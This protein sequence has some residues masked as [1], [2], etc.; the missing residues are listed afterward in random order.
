M[1]RA[2][3]LY[4]Q[5]G[6][7]KGNEKEKERARTPPS[8]ARYRVYERPLFAEQKSGL[9][10]TSERVK[11][12]TGLNQEQVGHIERLCFSELVKVTDPSHHPCALSPRNL[13]LLTL[14]WLWRYP[15]L[16]L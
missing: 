13:L 5:S 7:S 16:R 11:L 14:K 10:W 9:Q 3:I 2:R 8:T 6:N 12:E 4:S 15:P 1:F